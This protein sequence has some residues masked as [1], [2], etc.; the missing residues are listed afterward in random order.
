[1]PSPS[2]FSPPKIPIAPLRRLLPKSFSLLKIK[3]SSPTIGSRSPFTNVSSTRLANASRTL[4]IV[5]LILLSSPF[6]SFK[7][8]SLVASRTVVARLSPAAF[9]IS[10]MRVRPFMKSSRAD[11]ASSLCICRLL[12]R[13]CEAPLRIALALATSISASSASFLPIVSNCSEVALSIISGSILNPV[14]LLR[15]PAASLL[16]ESDTAWFTR[17]SLSLARRS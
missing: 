15:V 16:S 5:S 1:M 6:I 17:S 2:F 12:I 10:E 8:A 14:K 13:S 4:R 11:T 3:E 9:A 7:N